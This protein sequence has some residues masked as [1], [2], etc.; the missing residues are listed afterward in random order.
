MKMLTFPENNHKPMHWL[1]WIVLLL[2]SGLL[3]IGMTNLLFNAMEKQQQFDENIR[4]GRCARM[5]ENIP[6]Q[7]Q[8]YCDDLSDG[9]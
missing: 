3:M 6:R 8:H 2:L 1:Q 7:M 4:A 5:G 9:E